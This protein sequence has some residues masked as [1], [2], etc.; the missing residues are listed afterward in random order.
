MPTKIIFM[1]VFIMLNSGNAF[2]QTQKYVF[3]IYN[4]PRFGFTDIQTKAL[5]GQS[6]KHFSEGEKDIV[7]KVTKSKVTEKNLFIKRMVLFHLKTLNLIQAEEQIKER[8]LLLS[9]VIMFEEQSNRSANVFINLLS[10][11]E[12]DKDINL[13]NDLLGIS[14]SYLTSYLEAYY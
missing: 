6:P 3:D 1:L 12:A 2:A 14:K 7:F 11:M 8:R 10:E 13:S 9:R 4:I 5:F